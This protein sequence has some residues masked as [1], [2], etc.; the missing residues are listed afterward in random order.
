M[1]LE[2][3]YVIPLFDIQTGGPA[4]AFECKK[5]GHI[6]KTETGMLQHLRRSHDHEVQPC[7]FS[8]ENSKSPANGQPRKLRVLTKQNLER[9]K[10][11][12]GGQHEQKSTTD[13]P[14]KPAETSRNNIS[15]GNL[16]SPTVPENSNS[17]TATSTNSHTT[18]TGTK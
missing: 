3:D 16:N 9:T 6:S 14:P 10:N 8:M 1:F 7:L 12:F 15:A 4:R 18:T 11:P 17:A 13:E 5:C 2:N